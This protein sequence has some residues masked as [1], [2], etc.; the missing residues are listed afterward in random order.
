MASGRVAAIR[1]NVEAPRAEDVLTADDVADALG[2]H[3]RSLAYYHIKRAGIP[4]LRVGHTQVIRRSHLPALAAAVHESRSRAANT[5]Q[6]L[7][8][9]GTLWGARRAAEALGVSVRSLVRMAASGE[10][11]S[12]QLEGK[13]WWAP[14]AIQDL[15]RR[16]VGSVR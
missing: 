1:S 11:P 12:I 10:V 4:L 13:R 8:P 16:R 9:D 14:Q 2:L 6:G 15:A 5:R 3:T 7:S